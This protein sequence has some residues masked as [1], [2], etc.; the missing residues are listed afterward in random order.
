M[1][2]I[3]AYFAVALAIAL[4][5]FGIAQMAPGLG[6]PFVIFTSISWAAYSANR[7]HRINRKC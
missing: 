7:R 4:I 3:W 6:T 1:F 2:P 5:A